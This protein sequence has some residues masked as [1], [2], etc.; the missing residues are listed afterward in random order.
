MP[1]KNSLRCASNIASSTSS[2]LIGGFFVFLISFLVGYRHIETGM[3]VLAKQ[4]KTIDNGVAVWFQLSSTQ[5]TWYCISCD[6]YN[7]LAGNLRAIGL[8]VIQIRNVAHRLN[9]PLIRMFVATPPPPRQ[10]PPPPKQEYKYE[11]PQFW[12]IV[13]SVSINANWDET[14]RAYYKL[15]KIRHP[16][17]GGSSSQFQEL[18]R[19]Y[20]EAKKYFGVK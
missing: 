5:S 20:S 14:K 2:E 15:A 3:T 16:D 4:P 9:T 17:A 11:S 1:C 7:S 18:S 12:R 13:L 19:A 6:S 8:S 10:E